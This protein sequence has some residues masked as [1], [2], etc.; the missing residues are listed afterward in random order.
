MFQGKK[1]GGDGK[2][3]ADEHQHQV[4]ADQPPRAIIAVSSAID[5]CNAALDCFGV[6]RSWL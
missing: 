3:C 1:P 4:A 2:H 5:A 6:I